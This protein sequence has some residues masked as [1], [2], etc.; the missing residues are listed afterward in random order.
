VRLRCSC[1]NQQGHALWGD[2]GF[3]RVQTLSE[4][5]AWST[6]QCQLPQKDRLGDRCTELS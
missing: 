1:E 5:R 3:F 4:E 2:C 6:K